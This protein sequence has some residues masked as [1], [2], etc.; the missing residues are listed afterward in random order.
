MLDGKQAAG[1][2]HHEEGTAEA[3]PVQVIRQLAEV[4]RDARPDIG[5]GGDRRDA[6]ELPVLLRQLMGGGHE[7]PGQLLLDD[8]LDPT[9]CAG[10]R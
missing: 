6:L 9:S 5:V 1:R 2:L 4:G 10:L 8:L 7:D 3:V